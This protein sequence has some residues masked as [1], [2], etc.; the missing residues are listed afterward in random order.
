[1]A[2]TV[3]FEHEGLMSSFGNICKRKVEAYKI[4]YKDVIQEHN[5][6]IFPISED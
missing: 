3:I 6:S 4:L 5:A 2:V 1:M